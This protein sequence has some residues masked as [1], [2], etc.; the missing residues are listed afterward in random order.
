MSLALHPSFFSSSIEKYASVI[1]EYN[2]I[3]ALT[4]SKKGPAD[5][6]Q[7]K[8]LQLKSP[9]S[10][11]VYLAHLLKDRIGGRKLK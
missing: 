5:G 1:V 7:S 2:Y 11:K 3:Y 4:S 6:C 8:D 10:K 9:R